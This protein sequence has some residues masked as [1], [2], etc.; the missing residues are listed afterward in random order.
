MRERNVI[1][2]LFF[3]L[4][5]IITQTSKANTCICQYS[6]EE[7]TT[8][9]KAI[10]I[11]KVIG[12]DKNR[13]WLN[14]NPKSIFTFQVS[15]SYKGFSNY[16]GFVS[17]IAPIGG[18]E[19][20]YFRKDSIYLVFAYSDCKQTELLWTNNC[21]NSGLLTESL[22]HIKKLGTSLKHT[23]TFNINVK[24]NAFL[25][26]SLTTELATLQQDLQTSKKNNKQLTYF[27]LALGVIILTLLI[28]L[29]LGRRK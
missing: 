5:T 10:F 6:F 16:H 26:E 9:A 21:S 17:V 22:E 15:E 23:N 25:L 4:L 28:Y 11:G 19:E 29:G 2:F 18:C 3:L 8:N 7:D 24:E 12:I 27:L 13:F 20:G 1:R 14:G